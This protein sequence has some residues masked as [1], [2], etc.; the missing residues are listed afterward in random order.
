MHDLRTRSSGLVQFI[1]FHLELD[2]G[3]SVQDAHTIADA[4]ECTLKGALPSSEVIVHVEPAGIR[5]DRLDDRI[6][7]DSA[8]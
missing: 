3:L 7:S 1:E 5:D 4:I 6:E 2:G 8:P